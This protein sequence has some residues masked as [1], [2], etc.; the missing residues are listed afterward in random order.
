MDVR[1]ER[2]PERSPDGA[3][4]QSPELNFRQTD[5]GFMHL[6]DACTVSWD[7]VRYCLVPLEILKFIGKEHCKQ[8]MTI[9]QGPVGGTSIHHVITV[10]RA[11]GP[12]PSHWIFSALLS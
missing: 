7:R 4:H 3:V 11:Q 5:P 9:Q 8:A 6:E 1:K 12:G 2:H 10:S